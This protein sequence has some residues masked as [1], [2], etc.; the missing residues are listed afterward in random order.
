MRN[1]Q[2]YSQ[3]SLNVYK[4]EQ[5]KVKPLVTSQYPKAPKGVM[6]LLGEGLS[7]G[8]YGLGSHYEGPGALG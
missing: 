3:S 7:F 8:G 5:V 6:G 4:P 1:A 2:P